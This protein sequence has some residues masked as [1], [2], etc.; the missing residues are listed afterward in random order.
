MRKY[1]VCIEHCLAG[2]DTV[3]GATPE[4]LSPSILFFFF[5]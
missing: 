4:N 5:H 1:A 2:W 3:G